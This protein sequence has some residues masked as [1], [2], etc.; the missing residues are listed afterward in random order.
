MKDSDIRA[1]ITVELADEL[2]KVL[3]KVKRPTVERI[4]TSLVKF[5]VNRYLNAK[6]ETS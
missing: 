5:I 3:P 4:A 6:K 1:R 2:G